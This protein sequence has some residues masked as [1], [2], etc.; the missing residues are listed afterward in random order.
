MY[1]KNFITTFCI[2]AF[3]IFSLQSFSQQITTPAPSPAA[4]VSQSVGISTVTV[5]YSRPA[6]KGREVW[7]KLVPYGWERSIFW[8]WQRSSVE[9]RG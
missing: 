1:M 3:L 2:F 6:V 8:K 9:I 7:G 5:K 4:T